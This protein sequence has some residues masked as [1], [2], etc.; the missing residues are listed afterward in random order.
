M[1]CVCG[2]QSTNVKIKD[3]NKDLIAKIRSSSVANNSNSR[4]TVIIIIRV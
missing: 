4:S 1:A 3:M 2:R